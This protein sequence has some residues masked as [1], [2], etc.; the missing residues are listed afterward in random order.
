[1]AYSIVMHS[2]RAGET[3]TIADLEPGRYLIRATC[4]A[5]DEEDAVSIGVIIPEKSDTCTVNL[6]GNG[7][8]IDK[9]SVTF[10]F[11][12]GGRRPDSYTCSIDRQPAVACKLQVILFIH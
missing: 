2:G 7:M 1:M 12:G 8:V 10:E 5:D 3:V 6:V 4:A 11:G 9:D